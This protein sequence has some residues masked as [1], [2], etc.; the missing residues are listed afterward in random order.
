M[1]DRRVY[2]THTQPI[3]YPAV[4]PF[5]PGTLLPEC[6]FPETAGEPNAVY[7]AVRECFRLA[8]LDRDA[9]GTARWNPLG[10]FVAPGQRVLLKPNLVKEQHPRDPDGWVYMVT[11]GS[12]IRAVADYVW[13]ALGPNGSLVVADAPHTD[14]SFGEVTRRVGLHAIA[15][16]YRSRGL[17]FELRDLRNEEWVTRDSV[18]ATRR[19]L[20][21]DPAGT[22]AFDLAG[23]SEF[24]D[25]LGAGHYYGADY[26]TGEVN[27]H[28]SGG[29]HE[30]L[31]AN[32]ALLADVVISLP[33]LKTHKKVG[34]TVTLKN[35]VGINANK[36]WL[37]HHTEGTRRNG[38]DE[39]PPEQPWGRWER[40]GAGLFRRSIARMPCLGVWL[41]GWAR[42]CALRAI[43]GS[44]AAVR[45]GNWWGNDTAWRMC[46]DLNKIVAYGLPGGAMSSALNGVK[47]PHLALVDGV[48]AG[49]GAGPLD[50]DPVPAG[51][52][53]FG[54]N[55]A[56][57]DATCAVAMGFDPERIPLIR[58]AF[59]T[60]GYPLAH[61]DWP[62]VQVVSDRPEQN[63]FLGRWHHG[64]VARFRPHIG[65]VGHIES[66]S[67]VGQ[68]DG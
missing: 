68:C 47:R 36:N 56:S 5:H 31:I 49:D 24:A 51:I 41:H 58:Q 42:R 11:H 52:L 55:P 63:G 12:V 33:K 8:G 66:R 48:I 18:V 45:N 2:L 62:D 50:P 59:R 9:F 35:L 65:W 64:P 23:N 25:H 54:T 7:A 6:P 15:D 32:T 1:D 61:G 16:F 29:R 30:Y 43:G 67:P 40:A 3:C 34:I 28:H 60:R 53:L 4:P 46:L 26:E 10:T 20:A 22:T 13:L 27:Y 38:S 14:A 17:R 39:R 19:A 57:V 37:P 44:D 21:G